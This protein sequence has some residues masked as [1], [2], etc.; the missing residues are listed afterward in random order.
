F[1]IYDTNDNSEV[2][3]VEIKNIDA[4]PPT[5]TCSAIYKNGATIVTVVAS[6]ASGIKQYEYINNNKTLFISSNKTYSF[7]EYPQDLIVK[8]VDNQGYVSEFKCSVDDYAPLEI[9]FINLGRNDGILLR[10]SNTT[11]F[12]DGG[13]YYFSLTSAEYMRSLG[14]T[15]ID[16][17][18]G[19][20]LDDNHIHAQKRF[21]EEFEVKGVYYGDDPRTCA[22]RKTCDIS[23]ANPSSVVEAIDSKKVP[24]TILKEGESVKIG[25]LTFDVV[26]PIT[27]TGSVNVNSLNLIL[28]Y[29]DVKIFFAGD[30]IQEKEILNKYNT[31]ILDVDVLKYPHHGQ[32]TISDAFLDALT[33]KFVMVTHVEND[34]PASVQK[35]LKSLGAT[36]YITAKNGNM[37]LTVDGKNVD[38]KTNVNPANYKK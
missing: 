38:V 3:S 35:K 31:S 8:V 28:K 33:P 12:I 19:S 25:N 13:L 14:I 15:K 1:T 34:I 30:G 21:L 23:R 6:D 37:V 32:A 4:N 27:L 20:H 26:G 22:L 11:I 24:I 5:G 16:A 36:T 2:Y 9:H 10:G 17:L 29:G 18:I 7:G